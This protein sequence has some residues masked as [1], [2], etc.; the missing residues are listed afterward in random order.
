MNYNILSEEERVVLLLNDAYA[1]RVNDLT[2]S[3]ALAENALEISREIDNYALI[4]KSLNQLSLYYMIISDFEKSTKNSE[5]AIFYFKKLNDEGGIADAKY[6]IGS[7]HYKTNNYHLGLVY[8]LDALNIYRKTNDLFNQS[9]VEKAI[10]TIYEY[11]GDQYNAFKSYK[12]AIKIA[13]KI[14]D[15]NLES[16]V[17]NN[18]SGLFLK[19]QKPKLA[20][21]IIEYSIKLKKQTNDVRGYGFAI[22]G[23]GKVHYKIGEYNQAENKFLEAVATHKSMGEKMGTAMAFNKLGT[24]YLNLDLLDKAE[25][26]AFEGLDLSI[27]YNMSMIKIKNYHLLYLIF[28]KRGDK[29]KALEYLE[30]Y[31]KEKESV[32]NSQTLKVIEN[33]D[34]INKMNALEREAERQKEKQLIIDKK[35]HDEKEAVRLKQEFLSIMSHEIRTPLNAITTIVSMFNTQVDNEGKKMLKSLQFASNNLI[36]IVND[37]LDY[38]KL[39]LKKAKLE[40]RS[41]NFQELFDN[42]LSI[43]D[44]MAK[45]KG[46]VFRLITN[47]KASKSYLLDETKF[48]QILSN[49]IS[50]A[51]KFTDQGKVEITIQLLE[52]TKKY[53]TLLFKVTDSGEGMQQKDLSKIFT[54][55]SQLTPVM[56]RKQGGTGLGLAIVKK[57][58]ELHNSKIEVTSVI[59]EGSEFSFQLKLEKTTQKVIEIKPNFDE[60]KGKTALLAEDTPM[61]A[62]LMKKLLSNWGISSDHVV[63]G[64]QAFEQAK[65]KKYDFILMDIHMPEMN[66]FEATQLIR[67]HKNLNTDTPIFALTADVTVLNDAKNKLLFNGFLWKPFEIDKLYAALAQVIIQVSKV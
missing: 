11:I 56:T 57:L 20:L 26:V 38:T 53:D 52:E 36:S 54:S 45:E 46:L 34:L 58:I 18:L 3:I 24:L 12:S 1:G 64:N 60:L 51:I 22:Y 8:L 35:N 66:G 21:N 6:N 44:G 10:G 4:G 33:Y 15:F 65:E 14:E 16:N 2:K 39:D 49:L 31:L 47:I 43:Y 13:R 37:I 41:V 29:V 25:T 55:F 63:N 19:R 48:T 61:N 5:E 23:L 32:I 67:N 9:K 62:L 40:L 50:N 30:Y 59:G 17:Y 27:Q 42:I 7:V 28:K